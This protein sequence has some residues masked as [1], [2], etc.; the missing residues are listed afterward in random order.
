MRKDQGVSGD[1]QRIEQLGWMITLKVLDDKD[2]EL[3]LLDENYVSVI[4]EGFKWRDWAADCEGMTGDK[5]KEFIDS[6]LFPALENL[7]VSSS[8]GQVNR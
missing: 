3:E 6:E 4:P 8:N 7:D 2:A 1:A 5:L